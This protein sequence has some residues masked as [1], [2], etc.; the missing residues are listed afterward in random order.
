MAVSHDFTIRTDAGDPRAV[1][2]R[3]LTDDGWEV[4]TTPSGG[5]LA[6][7][8][9]VW[10]T[11]LFGAMAGKGFRQSLV[12]D[13]TDTPDGALHARLHRDMRGSAL[14]GGAIGAAKGKRTFEDV[15]NA[16]HRALEQERILVG[17]VANT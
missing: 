10:L 15:A 8:G 11:V 12:M 17:S 4:S 3:V 16:M 9:S 6:Q 7:R 2:H 5:F 14:K 13:F 1:I